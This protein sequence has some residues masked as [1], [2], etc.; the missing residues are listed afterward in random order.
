[1]NIRNVIVMLGPPGSGK[2]TQ[3]KLLA[4]VLNY[5]Y[6]SMGQYLRQYAQK[7]TELARKIKKAIDA[8]KI[9]PDDWIK[10]IFLKAVKNF[11]KSEGVILDG[12]PRDIN[13]E[14]ILDNFMVKRETCQLKVIFL[15]V[16]LKD[17]LKRI[18]K[19]TGKRADDNPSVIKTRFKEYKKKTLPLKKYYKNKGVLLEI[20]GNHP[21]KEVHRRI[22]QKLKNLKAP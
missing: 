16:Y 18:G 5:N 19:R 22:V 21:I 3:G 8:G 17:L 1:M 15:N 10:K 9:I 7:N 6:L 4:N 12:F 20:D 13:Q 14:P 11:H 2:G